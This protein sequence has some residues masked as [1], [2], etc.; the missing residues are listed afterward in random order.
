MKKGKLYLIPTPLGDEATHTLPTY[1]IALTHTLDTFIVERA[2]TARHFLK[3]IAT[4]I[5][6]SAI[7][8]LELNEHTRP[9][10]VQ[11]LLDAVLLGK[12]MG[13]LSEAGCPGVADPGAAVVALAHQKGIEVVPFVGP[14][15]ILLGL[16]ASGF[17]GQQFAFLGYLPAKTPERIKAIKQLEQVFQR[18][19]QTQIFIETPYRN[20]ALLDDLLKQLAPSTRLCI[21]MNLTTATERILTKTV[22]EWRKKA[23]LD[24]WREKVPTIFLVG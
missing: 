10:E 23:D 24:K 2:K 22:A 13:L 1:L 7:E 14:S 12:N 8:M 21:G 11:P 16:M 19:Q 9:E 6:L 15:S 5:P 18:T 3:A 20:S 17:N 4:P